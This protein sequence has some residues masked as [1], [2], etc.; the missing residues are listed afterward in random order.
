MIHYEGAIYYY[1]SLPYVTEV[2]ELP[3]D[4]GGGVVLCHPELGRLSAN[5]WGETYE[6]AR[7][8]LNEIKRDI[9]QRCL[10]EDLH[11][12]VPAGKESK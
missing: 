4:Q 2:V 3:E 12:P 6:E 9:F 1:M 10:D 5:A 11:I 7:L 8:M